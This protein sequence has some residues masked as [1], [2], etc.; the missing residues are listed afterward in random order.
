MQGGKKE[1]KTQL[2]DGGGDLRAPP[3]YISKLS[4]EIGSHP[5]CHKMLSI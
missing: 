2:I 4:K 5:A 3:N 1:R